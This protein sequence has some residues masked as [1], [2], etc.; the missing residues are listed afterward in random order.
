[1]ADINVGM[2]VLRME[3]VGGMG[4]PRFGMGAFVPGHETVQS[5][6]IPFVFGMG[7]SRYARTCH[8]PAVMEMSV[9]P[10]WYYS[11]QQLATAQIRTR[12]TLPSPASHSAEVNPDIASSVAAPKMNQV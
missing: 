3:T 4:Y 5:P 6:S 7:L 10:P 12:N 9:L 11:A 2:P 8:G 1:M